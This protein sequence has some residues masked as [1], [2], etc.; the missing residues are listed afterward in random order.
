MEYIDNFENKLDKLLKRYREVSAK[1]S[2]LKG[3]RESL[4]RE[5]RE[6]IKSIEDIENRLRKISVMLRSLR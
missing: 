5:K 1:Y 3:D 4:E 6:L 2:R